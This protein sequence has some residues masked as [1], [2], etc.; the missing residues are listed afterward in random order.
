[1][2]IWCLRTGQPASEYLN[3]SRRQRQAFIDVLDRS[4]G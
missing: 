1:M 3:L 4:K 2:A